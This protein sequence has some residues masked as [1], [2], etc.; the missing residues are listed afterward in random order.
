M[1]PTTE[2]IHRKILSSLDGRVLSRPSERD[3]KS[4]PLDI[5]LR[6]PLPPRV[7]FIVFRARRDEKGRKVS[8][9][10][11]QLT[12]GSHSGSNHFDRSGGFTPVLLG[13]VADYDIVILFDAQMQEMGGGYKYSKSCYVSIEGVLDAVA[14]GL[15]VEDVGL[16]KPSRTEHVVLC[17]SSRLADALKRRTSLSIDSLLER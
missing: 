6:A 17:R 13:Y 4:K 1:S 3:L 14:T 8:A 12:I 2:E 11:I 10:R 15:A 16:R 9:Y 7:R 5:E